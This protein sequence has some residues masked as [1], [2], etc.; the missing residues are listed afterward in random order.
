MAQASEGIRTE[1]RLTEM[2]RRAVFLVAMVM[3]C[4][5][6][7]PEPEDPS[8]EGAADFHRPA[9]RP[10]PVDATAPITSCNAMRLLAT[11]DSSTVTRLYVR[12]FR[13]GRPVL[14]T[15][16]TG[17]PVSALTHDS[18]K[19]NSKIQNAEK[20]R[21]FCDEQWLDSSPQSP[22]NGGGWNVDGVPVI[23][24]IGN[25]VLDGG[26]L[27]V[28]ARR[29]LFER[30][31]P[32]WTPSGETWIHVPLWSVKGILVTKGEVDGATYWLEF[33]TGG[34]LTMLFDENADMSPPVTTTHDWVGN[35][36]SFSERSGRLK[37]GDG[38]TRKV[39]VQRTRSYPV[40]EGWMATTGIQGAIGITSI[41][42]DH[43]VIDRAR[44][45][46]YLAPH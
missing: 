44:G 37:L 23:G 25:D 13:Q 41:D 33:D 1:T 28:D 15:F 5:G 9:P 14:M 17:V 18:S 24:T 42:S 30:H 39:R 43:F 38:P 6:S 11:R 31:P 22:L 32:E 36:V 2:A 45:Q 34:W 27:E 26:V 46:L 3:G 40:F 7:T 8:S 16:D 19:Q 20:V 21:I 10:E 29:R 12:V 4:G 35:E